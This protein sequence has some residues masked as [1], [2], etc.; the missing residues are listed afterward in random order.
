MFCDAV[1]CDA[2]SGGVVSGAGL[3]VSRVRAAPGPPRGSLP[4]APGERPAATV[5]VVDA[6]TTVP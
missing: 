3:A 1:F 4:A 6:A 5:P 2:M